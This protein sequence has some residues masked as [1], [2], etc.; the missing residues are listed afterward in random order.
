MLPRVRSFAL[1]F[2]V[3]V[4][5]AAAALFVGN[6]I[7]TPSFCRSCSL[8]SAVVESGQLTYRS[9]K[10]ID[11]RNDYRLDQRVTYDGVNLRMVGRMHGFLDRRLRAIVSEDRFDIAIS[12]QAEDERCPRA[13]SPLYPLALRRL[14]FSLPKGYAY[15]GKAWST[16][17]CEGALSCRYEIGE[18][19]ADGFAVTLTCAGAVAAGME[20]EVFLRAFFADEARW[21]RSIEG[22]IRVIANPLDARWTISEEL[23]DHQQDD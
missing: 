5:V 10:R 20:S 6:H 22:T 7:M 21:Y 9:G 3:A 2:L 8:N 17:Y 15:P 1:L 23:R 4:A 16:R 14:L 19:R 18:V 11:L 13:V 12:T